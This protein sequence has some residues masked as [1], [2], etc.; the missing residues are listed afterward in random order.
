MLVVKEV[1]LFESFRVR[2]LNGVELA[3]KTSETCLN[4]Y[5]HC[6]S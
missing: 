1:C 2:I 4:T 5:K 3:A 6:N